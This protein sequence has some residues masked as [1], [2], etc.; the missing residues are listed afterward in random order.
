MSMLPCRSLMT[1]AFVAL[2]LFLPFGLGC[3]TAEE[4][5]ISEKEKQEQKD[6]LFLAKLSARQDLAETYREAGNLDESIKELT[7]IGD[8]AE[9]KDIGPEGRRTCL[10]HES[11]LC[12][13]CRRSIG[14]PKRMLLKP[15]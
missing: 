4:C 1:V 11:A 9:P 5:Q 8:T 6:N 13:T 15:C 10:K 3:A 12:S 7:A 14:N 2:L